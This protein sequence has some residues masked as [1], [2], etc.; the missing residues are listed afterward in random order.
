MHD[1]P[2]EPL[3]QT[4]L[5]M[6]VPD[7][8]PIKLKGR[9][10]VRKKNIFE[11]AAVRRSPRVAVDPSQEAGAVHRSPRVAAD[12]SPVKASTVKASPLAKKARP[13]PDAG[14]VKVP[15]SKAKK[16]SAK[17]KKRQGEEAGSEECE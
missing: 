8:E 5:A 6:S 3:E 14:T 9:V 7:T 10:A 12:P 1:K 2:A 16:M 11:V 4:E 15:A 13:N 17:V